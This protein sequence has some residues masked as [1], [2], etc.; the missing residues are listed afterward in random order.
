MESS[1]MRKG[2]QRLTKMENTGR[3]EAKDNLIVFTG[4]G[5]FIGGSLIRV[6]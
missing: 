2:E 6:A 5:G 3:T 1:E 4:A